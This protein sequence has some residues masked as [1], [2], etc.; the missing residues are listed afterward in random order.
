MTDEELLDRL[1]WRLFDTMFEGCLLDNHLGRN[2]YD[3]GAWGVRMRADELSR[4]I[5]LARKGQA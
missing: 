1:E 4:L 3:V 5:D 2:H